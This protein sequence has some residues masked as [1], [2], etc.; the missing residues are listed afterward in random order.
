[1]VSRVTQGLLLREMLEGFS[2]LQR[3]LGRAQT[4]VASGLRI[5]E[6]SDDPT[7]TAQLNR[8]RS[9]LADLGAIKDGVSFG[10]TVLAAEDAALEESIALLTRA[11]ELATQHSNELSTPAARQQAALEVEE[12]ERGLL[13]LANTRV[14]GRYV[15]AGLATGDA[16]FTQYDD[17]GYDPTTAYTGTAEPFSIRTGPDDVTTRLTT[18]G[19]QVFGDAI[20]A[21]DN[22]RLALAAG[23]PPST[24]L[25]AVTA[26]TDTIIAERASIGG[27]ARRLEDRLNEIANGVRD[28]KEIIGTVQDADLAEVVTE[29]AKIQNALNATLESAK[30]LQTSILDHF[31]L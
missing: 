7:G 13:T 24:E 22:L 8:L 31:R 18:P 4:E 5:H 25:D 30:A 20:I 17:P 2:D 23:S 19:D 21:L 27:R 28:T 1:M 26:A 12:L 16:P 29:L 3:R 14:A 6:P 15:F 10:V 11:R 9:D